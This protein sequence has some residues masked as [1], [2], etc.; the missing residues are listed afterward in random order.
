MPAENADPRPS[1]LILSYSPLYRDA[2]VLRQ[3]RR[4]VTDY[5]VTTVGYGPAPDGVVAH[6]RIPDDIVYWH[7]D[8]RLMI[9]RLYQ[10]AYDTA[11]VTRHL[12]EVLRPGEADVVL[13]NDVDTVPLAV[14]LAPRGGV[15]ADLH[16]YSSRQKEESRIW[17]VF[18]APYY[19][20]LVRKWVRRADSA[21]TVGPGLAAQYRSE[22][23]VEAGVV[24]N[25]PPHAD[26]APTPVA[27]PPRLVH[28]GNGVAARLEVML[29]AM[30]LVTSGATLDLYL[31]D[32]GNGY[33]PELRRRFA[34]HPRVRV[35]DPVPTDEVVRTLS[36][37]DVGAYVL[38]PISFNFRYAL[39]NK[40]FDFVQA[41]LALVVGPSPEM[42]ALVREHRLGVVTDDF[43]AESLAAAIDALTPEVVA[44]GKAASHTAAE[45]LSAERAVQGWA[46]AVAALAARAQASQR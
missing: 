14:T 8:R 19:R 37:Y 17:R 21:T 27:D 10:R 23:G 41:R 33:V 3:I 20:F 45:E 15:H 5:A 2:R 38:P 36:G 6:H 1:L 44:A 34:G 9:A 11:P 31:I 40:F 22:F 26:L 29:E 16:E 18:V 25:A 13:A 43:T 28:A 7:K 46:D 35:H 24:V 30:D 42:A 39:P 4:F 12:R 32:Q